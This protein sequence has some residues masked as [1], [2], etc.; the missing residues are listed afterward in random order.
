MKIIAAAALAAALAAPAAAFDNTG[1]K[2]F[3][4]G[5]WTTEA[6]EEIEGV[7]TT[8]SVHSVY[9]ADGAFTQTMEMVKEGAA[10]QSMSRSGTW[11]AGPGSKPDTCLA[12]LFPAGEAESTIELTVVDE[13][14]VATPDGRQSHRAP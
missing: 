6:Q 2:A 5:T 8:I 13:N 11:D 10:P 1:C 9:S 7:K 14:T 12:K 4:A 3:L